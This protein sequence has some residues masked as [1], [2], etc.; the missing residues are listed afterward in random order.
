MASENAG[1]R[2]NDEE[3]AM[4]LEFPPLRFR[5][6]LIKPR[7]RERR[8]FGT[9]VLIPAAE[10]R[11]ISRR[12]REQTA[13]ID[14]VLR[15]RTPDERRAIF[16]RLKHDRPLTR[17]D[18]TGTGLA[19][20]SAPGAD[21]SLV[22]TRQETLELLEKR[23]QKF[24]EGE[25]PLR[26][27]GT[28]FA[29]AVRAVEL[30]EPKDRLSDELLPQLDA[31]V[32]EPHVVYEIEIASFALRSKT[33]QKEV[34]SI[35]EEVHASLAKGVHGAIFEAEVVEDGARAVL[36]STGAKLR[37]FVEDRR[38]WRKIVFFDARPKFE[39]FSQVF[40]N[41]NVGNVRIE[42]PPADSETICV[43]D[44]GVAAGNPFLAGVIQPGL[45]RSFLSGF[46]PTADANG[47][48]S[49]V[50]SLA[51]YYQLE[52]AGG[53]ENRAAA[54]IASARITTDE[55]QL[56]IPQ[57]EN[58]EEDRRQQARL[59]SNILREIV[60]HYRPLGVK[61]FVLAFQIVG[62]VWSKAARRL[63]ARS[64]WVARAIDQLSREHDVLF[65][66]ITGNIPPAE[67]AELNQQQ[68]YPQY[69]LHPLA[70]LLDP[71]Q[72]ALAVTVGS[73]AHGAKVIVA[74]QAP[75]ALTSQPSPFTRSGPGF[76]DAN[77]PDFV[78]RG[79]NVVYDAG[80]G[81]V[82][83]NAGTN[84]VMASGRLTPALQHGN[85][86]SFAAPR[87]A[88]Q[89]ALLN[90]DLRQLG[91]NASAPLLRAFL[92]A[93]ALRSPESELLDAD[94][95]LAVLGYGVPDGIRATNCSNSSALLFWQGDLQADS[96]AI[97]RVPVPVEI[98][99]AGRAPKRIIVAVATAPPVQAWG[100]A[101]YLGAEAKFWLF[102][103]DQNA[104]YI[105]ALVQREESETNVAAK[106]GVD[107]MPSRLGITRRS[108][109]TLQCD[110]FE[111]SDHKEDYSAAEYT[112]AISLKSATW[113]AEDTRVPAAIVVRVEDT[114]G[115]CQVVY[116]RVRAQVEAVVR[117]RA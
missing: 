5:E 80:S 60:Q 115:R 102:R 92:A 3:A 105:E 29:T 38:W 44:T 93:S 88:H 48:G 63:V 111:W 16:L 8:G 98:M 76:A 50:A 51:A 64:A 31:L 109:G 42:A 94:G 24:T 89:I 117:A 33:R 7:R 34:A 45:S 116:A 56:D 75:L 57:I 20:M 83:A 21:E 41:F 19:F 68:H 103:G 104:E 79:G 55:G 113:C 114:T 66:T 96:T 81:M 52:I 18:L 91:M 112:L 37:E 12:I 15:E 70:K 22:V 85:G 107:H 99:E 26:P 39:T 84:V 100:V 28:D 61:I 73:I 49:G 40:Q 86:T 67:I 6:P 46:E 25:E 36:W 106:V 59:L 90:R 72:A 47:H 78:E 9:P 97:F 74:P 69:L 77:K 35:I 30:G 110:S 27:K 53:G 54:Y 4:N 1:S 58:Q 43:I 10:R 71:G 14:R 62:H 11:E 2:R 95:N 82:S 65:V 13:E 32:G 23:L 108:V 87:V 17:K 101:E